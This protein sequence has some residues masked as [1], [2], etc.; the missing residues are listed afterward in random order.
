MTNPP[1]I[2]GPQTP[3]DG[4]PE[5]V[6]DERWAPRPTPSPAPA[7]LETT[8]PMFAVLGDLV[9]T[10][11]WQ[12]AR[13]TTA[14]SFMGNVKLDLR[15]VLQPGET[16]EV[17]AWAM[18]G[19]VRVIVPPGTDVE[20]RGVTVMGNGQTEIDVAA[21]GAAPTGARVVVNVNSLM[22]NVRVR[23]MGVGAKPPGGWRWARPR[24]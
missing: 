17:E 18:L 16:M 13:H 20:V 8:D 11:R 12:A 14:Y 4:L 19:D 2:P 9:R 3:G 23:T 6:P 10:G 15:E 24:S 22:G 5:I 21:Q 1:P 7:R